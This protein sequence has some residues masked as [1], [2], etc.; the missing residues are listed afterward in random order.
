LPTKNT[1]SSNAVL[2]P[3]WRNKDLQDRDKLKQFISIKPSL[4]K[5]HKELFH[6]EEKEKQSQ[7]SE[8]KKE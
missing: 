1:L 7:K 3:E 5:I 4:Q 2:Q 8:V 6:I